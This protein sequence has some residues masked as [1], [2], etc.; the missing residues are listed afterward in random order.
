MKVQVFDKNLRVRKTSFNIA[1]FYMILI[2]FLY[3]LVLVKLDLSA[4][5]FLVLNFIQPLVV[6]GIPLVVVLISENKF[7]E[8]LPKVTYELPPVRKRVYFYTAI[9]AV[10]GWLFYTYLTYF[11]TG[12]YSAAS[13]TIT[14]RVPVSGV[15][16][17]VLLAVLYSA[18]I[19]VV[20]REYFFRYL[21][22]KAYGRS[23]YGYI[24]LSLLSS[25]V[26]Y[27]WSVAFRLFV[28]GLLSTAVFFRY[29]R[30]WFSFIVAAIF[31][32]LQV[33]LPQFVN[34][35][36]ASVAATSVEMALVYGLFDGAVAC[37]LAGCIYWL[38]KLIGFKTCKTKVKMKAFEI[39][40]LV[41]C[42]V[43]FISLLIW[44]KFI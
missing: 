14:I 34:L 10:V 20:L 17:E 24:I 43:G 26:C 38:V 18:V 5:V 16:Y 27:D 32:S 15:W 29:G 28:L 6:F 42:V 40:T 35:P 41:L 3:S 4:N 33:I 30:I 13:Q 31:E 22:R 21:G 23:I 37:F 44:K 9:L 2:G 36:I 8:T 11:L 7:T 25:L 1:I 12:M 39:F 19:A